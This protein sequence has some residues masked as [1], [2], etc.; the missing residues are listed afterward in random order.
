LNRIEVSTNSAV[1]SRVCNW[2]RHKLRH[3]QNI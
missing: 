2:W 1:S 3:A